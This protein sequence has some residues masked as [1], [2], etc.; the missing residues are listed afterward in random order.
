[1]SDQVKPSSVIFDILAPWASKCTDVKN[2]KW[3]LNLVWHRMLYSC[4]LYPYG[5][6]GRQRVKKRIATFA[7][8]KLSKQRF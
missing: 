2:Y 5:N 3:Q 7:A 4:L 8:V 1:M 6:S